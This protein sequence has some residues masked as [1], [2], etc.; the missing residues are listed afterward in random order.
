MPVDTR[1]TNM[2]NKIDLLISKFDSH[3]SDITNRMDKTT[4]LVSE[5]NNKISDI[6]DKVDSVQKHCEENSNKISAAELKI[7]S[8]EQYSRRNNIRI[9]GIAES[10]TE[11]TDEIVLEFVKNKLGIE[12]S[13]NDIERSH[14]VGQLTDKNRALLVKFAS[15]RSK[16]KIFQVKKR[17]KGSGIS[18]AEDLTRARLTVYQEAKR[19][20]GKNKAWTRDGKI[21]WEDKG[22][23]HSATNLDGLNNKN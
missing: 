3:S 17:L 5:L 10:A 14:R 18:I 23:I 20:H 2:E 8:L 4:A 22:K 19:V 11:S 15:Y 16:S 13:A 7:D 21:F 9:F 1:K 12:L 6:I